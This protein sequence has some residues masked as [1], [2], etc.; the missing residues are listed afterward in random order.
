MS[1]YHTDRTLSRPIFHVESN[2]AV[3]SSRYQMCSYVSA[4][5]S[6]AS[7]FIPPSVGSMF[8]CKCNGNDRNIFEN[9]LIYLLS[10]GDGSKKRLSKIIT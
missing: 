5:T 6:A 2:G 1:A 8:G 3:G 4:S 10:C 7:F 9:A